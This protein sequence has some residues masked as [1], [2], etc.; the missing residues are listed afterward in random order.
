[1]RKVSL[2]LPAIL[3]AMF[4]LGCAGS[5]MNNSGPMFIGEGGVQTRVQDIQDTSTAW[6]NPR[7]LN[8]KVF[9]AN[10][11]YKMAENMPPSSKIPHKQTGKFIKYPMANKIQYI[12]LGENP[13]A[14]KRNMEAKL[15][16]YFYL[17]SQASLWGLKI[18]GCEPSQRMSGSWA[19]LGEAYLKENWEQSKHQYLLSNRH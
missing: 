16:G 13:L 4:L 9:Q 5:G 15:R 12:G 1:M 14:A 18:I 10:P 3:M 19:C 17:N 7:P 2:F 11:L 8:L 6:L